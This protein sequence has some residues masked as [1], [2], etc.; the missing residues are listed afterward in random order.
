MR[1]I[2]LQTH[3]ALFFVML[4]TGQ[5]TDCPPNSLL[6]GA[7]EFFS[8]SMFVREHLVLTRPSSISNDTEI[9]RRSMQNYAA[10]LRTRK[11]M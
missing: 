11:C 10:L 9:T 8:P 6:Q 4:Y 2:L 7:E 1:Q 3:I 5:W